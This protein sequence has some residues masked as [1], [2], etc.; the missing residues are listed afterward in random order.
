MDSN[1]LRWYE[2]V[3]IKQKKAEAKSESN[4]S[5]LIAFSSGEVA[6][7]IVCSKNCNLVI[8]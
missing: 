1:T 8:K 2:V 3:K 7:L 5:S 6:I 4:Q